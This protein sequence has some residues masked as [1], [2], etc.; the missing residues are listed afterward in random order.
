[1]WALHV[2]EAGTCTP[3]FDPAG[4]AGKRIACGVVR[5]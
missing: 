5:R 3:P 2:Q 1:M 4:N